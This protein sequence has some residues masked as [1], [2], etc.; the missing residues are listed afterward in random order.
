MQELKQRETHGQR[1]PGGEHGDHA[2]QAEDAGLHALPQADRDPA[3]HDEQPAEQY[4]DG[5]RIVQAA[6][7]RCSGIALWRQLVGRRGQH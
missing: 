2:R 5:H 3:A 4:R 1:H 6:G 7:D